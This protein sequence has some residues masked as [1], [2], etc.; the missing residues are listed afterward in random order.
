MDILTLYEDF[1]CRSTDAPTKYHRYCAASLMGTLLGRRVWLQHGHRRLFPHTWVCLI[2]PSGV[3]KTTSLGIAEDLIAEVNPGAMLPAKFSWEKL[4]SEIATTPAGILVY[5]ELHSFLTPLGRDFNAEAKSGLADLWDSPAHRGYATK[6]GGDKIIVKYPALS[7]LA[8]TTLSWF[9]E[10]AKSRDIEGG[11]FARMLFVVVKGSDV[12]PMILPPA[13]D[14]AKA[15][16]LTTA[17]QDIQLRFPLE[18]APAGEMKMTPAATRAYEGAFMSLKAAYIVSDTLAPFVTRGQVYILKLAMIAAMG[19][20][21]DL[22]IK[23]EDIEYGHALVG[24]SLRDIAEIIEYEVA[25][26]R[27]DG[28]LK[29]LRQLIRGSGPEGITSRELLRRGPVRRSDWLKPLLR[30][31]EDTGEIRPLPGKKGGEKHLWL[32]EFPQVAQVSQVSQP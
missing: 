25:V 26:D 32:G 18:M 12:A 29:K 10:T 4:F 3:K 13:R 15:A 31:L 20:R 21:G 24:D 2:G 8:G 5:G 27:T 23:A 22:Q 9:I 16:A 17:L 11:F 28:Q 7:I 6:G 14:P 30:T 19:R 1:A